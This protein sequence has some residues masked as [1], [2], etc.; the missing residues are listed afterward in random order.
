M[1]DGFGSY[2][3]KEGMRYIGDWKDNKRHGKGSIKYVDGTERVGL[4]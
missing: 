1:K 3:W 2:K 4:W